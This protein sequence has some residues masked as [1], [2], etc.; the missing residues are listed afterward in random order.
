MFITG[1]LYWGW[2]FEQMAAVFFLMGVAAGLI[3]GLG[4]SGT[5]EAFVEGFSSMAFAALLIGFARAI[6]VVLEDGQVIDTLVS[7]L[8]AP[9]AH[10]PVALSAAAMVIVQAVLHPLVPSVSGQ[11]VLT[12]PVLLPLADLLK[13]S[14]QVVVLAF[15]YGAGI[16]EL[17]IPTN[18]ALMAILGAARVPYEDWLRFAVPLYLGLLA[19]GLLAVIL[20]VMTGLR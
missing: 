19:L 18:G 1:V 17:L 6:L 8:F 10:F 5:A 3:G 13:M 15:Q 4:P 14:R 11:A 20:G 12:L 9:L 16:C 7:A 2:D